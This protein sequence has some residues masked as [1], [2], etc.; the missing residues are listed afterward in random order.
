MRLCIGWLMVR[1]RVLCIACCCWLISCFSMYGCIALLLLFDE[2]EQQL[3]EDVDMDDVVELVGDDGGI[4]W[5]TLLIR[6]RFSISRALLFLSNGGGGSP[7]LRPLNW[8]W[9]CCMWRCC[10]CWCPPFMIV[11]LLLFGWRCCGGF[12]AFVGTAVF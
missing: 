11:L 12:V 2:V 1:C 7:K 9:G 6:S 8:L 5:T 4:C 3:D 10:C